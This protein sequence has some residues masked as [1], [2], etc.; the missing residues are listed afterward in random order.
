MIPLPSPSDS[1]YSSVRYSN[2]EM[3]DHFTNIFKKMEV[4]KSLAKSMEYQKIWP[5]IR[6]SI[7]ETDRPE[8]LL[9]TPYYYTCF[10]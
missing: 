2:A 7:F 9:T 10:A 8:A 5:M 6:I 4:L 1:S 3:E